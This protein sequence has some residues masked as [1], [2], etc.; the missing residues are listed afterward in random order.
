MSNFLQSL[1]GRRNAEPASRQWEDL[2]HRVDGLSDGRRISLRSEA[3]QKRQEID[4]FMM[5]SAPAGEGSDLAGLP[6]PAGTDWKWRPAVFT[7]SLPAIGVSAPESGSYVAP[8]LVV[9]HDIKDNLLSV[10]QIHRNQHD[11]LPPYGVQFDSFAPRD[12]GYI[13]LT[14]DLPAEALEDLDKNFVLRVMSVTGAALSAQIYLRLNV[15]HGPNI[16]QELRHL[17]KALD[18]KTVSLITEFDLGFVEMNP[19]RM[20]KIWLDVIVERPEFN[21]FAL[22]DL[23]VSR[24]L[25]ADM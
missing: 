7:G 1:F 22:R 21:S 25:R 14:F 24:H 11:G 16:E 15:E 3:R 5:L 12:Q 23:V 2:A 18:G 8:D 20:Q 13:A 6:F 17:D 4:R 19:R 10:R 9:W